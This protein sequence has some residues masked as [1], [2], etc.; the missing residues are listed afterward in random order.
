MALFFFCRG[1]GHSCACYRC[2]PCFL[3]R[4]SRKCTASA[5]NLY[6]ALSS[7]MMAVHSVRPG[8][9]FLVGKFVVP[10]LV[11]CL[12]N[13]NMLVCVMSTDSIRGLLCH[14]R[15]RANIFLNVVWYSHL[16]AKVLS[17]RWSVFYT[18]LEH[19]NTSVNFVR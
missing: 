5:G 4:C 14:H 2:R 10:V 19:C 13:I 7:L 17:P 11:N 1:S 12:A 8:V 3:R 16:L 9:N 6:L 18:T 15:H